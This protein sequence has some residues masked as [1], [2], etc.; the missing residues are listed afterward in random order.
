MHA[1][2]A[3]CE[4][5][6]KA[7]GQALDDPRTD[8]SMTMVEVI[9]DMKEQRAASQAHIQQL[10]DLVTADHESKDSFIAR[11]KAVLDECDTSALDALHARIAELQQICRDAYEVYAGSE[12]FPQPTTASE[13][14]LF[15][16]LHLMKDEIARGL[17]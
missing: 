12:G 6:L 9:Q 4:T 11:V 17:K 8:L 3:A 14:Y 16:Q 5:E 15:Q 10:R 1:K 2:L 13:A 7:I